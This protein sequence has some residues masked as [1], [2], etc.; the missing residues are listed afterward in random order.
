MLSSTASDPQVRQSASFRIVNEKI[1]LRHMLAVGLSFFFR[2]GKNKK[3][4]STV[5]EFI[6]NWENPRATSDLMNFC[7]ENQYIKDSLLRIVPENMHIAIGLHDNSWIER[8]AGNYREKDSHFKAEESEVCSD[9]NKLEEIVNRRAE[10]P[11]KL[12]RVALMRQETISKESTLDFLS[13][14]AIIPKYGFPVDVV[15]LDTRTIGK[16]TV[17]LQR[18]LSQAIAEYAPGC[19]VVANKFEWSSCGVKL[20]AGKA[21]PEAYYKYDDARNFKEYEKPAKG[22]RQYV[23]PVFGF[24][25]PLNRRPEEPTRKRTRLY[26]TRPFFCGFENLETPPPTVEI[27]G[28]QITDAVPGE[29]VILCEG[30]KKSGFFFCMTCGT[31]MPNSS[32]THVTPEGGKCNG[33]LS[34]RS[35]GHKL[36]TDVVRLRFPD[37]T[38][39]WEAY[40]LAY[41]VLLGASDIFNV[42]ETDLNV[43]LSGDIDGEATI[44][45]Y[46]NVPGGAGLV[47]KLNSEIVFRKILN[48]ARKHVSGNCGCNSSCYGCLRSYRN[49][50]AHPHLHR[51][52]ALQ[53]IDR[54]LKSSNS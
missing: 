1:V 50:F 4:F 12:A 21:L 14:R 10:F 51:K 26:T 23:S 47:A 27:F 40:S 25:S 15:E 22:R 20:V 9:Y 28:V 35:L 54:A 16:S 3:R 43:T 33:K 49:Q 17:Q 46:D 52:H 44:I 41:A 38:D 2:D 13:R 39:Q 36:V 48:E 53:F 24:V 37:L 45:L 19:R 8:L 11:G 42:P 18:D 7:K 32:P 6:G 29:L 31:H 5:A 30:H 34:N